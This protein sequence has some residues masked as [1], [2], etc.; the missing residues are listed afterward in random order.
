VRLHEVGPRLEL[1]LVKVEEGLAAG[2]VLYH[3]HVEI[4]KQE[5]D[6]QQAAVDAA[7]RLKAQRRQQQEQNVARKAAEKRRRAALEEAAAAGGGEGA[8]AKKAR[9]AAQAGWTPRGGDPVEEDDDEAYFREEVGVRGRGEREGGGWWGGGYLGQSTACLGEVGVVWWR[10]W[11]AAEAVL[12]PTSARLWR[13]GV[14][15]HHTL[16]LP[17]PA[18]PAAA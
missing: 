11:R 5:A 12:H 15:T 8:A 10:E 18:A 14:C 13:R 17:A 4:S 6:A 16:P 3:A 7:A 2:R 1:E 9:K